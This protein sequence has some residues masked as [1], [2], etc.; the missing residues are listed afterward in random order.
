MAEDIGIIS[1]HSHGYLKIIN[2][3]DVE[4]AMRNTKSNMAAARFLGVSKPTYKKYASSYK[5]EDGVS[6]YEKHNNK[7]G[8]GIPKYLP[9]LNSRSTLLRIMSG[10][11]SKT[12]YSTTMFKENLIKEGIIEEKCCRCDFH[13][14]RVLDFRVPLILN[15]KDG[16]KNRWMLDNLEFL[17][18]NCYYLCIGDI[19]DKKQLDS[20][21]DITKPSMPVPKEFE[22]PKHQ[23]EAIVRSKNLDNA[24]R[25]DDFGDDLIVNFK[26]R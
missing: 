8:I 23:E 4:R 7:T 10:E 9:N 19:F 13:E 2:R 17:C 5:D 15:F 26:R 14:R 6:L 20:L 18:Y 25:P 21:E 22:L 1:K 3:A 12:F 24:E 11:V 16:N